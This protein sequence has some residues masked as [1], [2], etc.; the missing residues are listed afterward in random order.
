MSR[1]IPLIDF[2]SLCLVDSAVHVLSRKKCL[3]LSLPFGSNELPAPPPPQL[4]SGLRSCLCHPESL[5]RKR[6][7]AVLKQALGP[8]ASQGPWSS[9]LR[10]LEMCEEF[11]G[12]LFA[13]HW[14]DQMDRIHGSSAAKGG[15]VPAPSGS[16][17]RRKMDPGAVMAGLPAPA[18]TP[19]WTLALWTRAFNHE[20]PT[21][22]RAVVK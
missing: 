9:Y 14:A 7:L 11:S 3:N 4:W 1:M 15:H 6:A 17:S 20:N 18:Y 19:E 5:V 12:H 22:V 8:D 21:V 10:L 16:N 13:E 2:S